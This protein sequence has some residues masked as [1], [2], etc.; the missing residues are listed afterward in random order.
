MKASALVWVCAL[1][2]AFLLGSS[3]F[4]RQT[5]T[6]IYGPPERADTVLVERTD[7]AV[8]LALRAVN[9]RQRKRI[10][11]LEKQQPENTVVT[12]YV[13]AEP[14]TIKV[15]DAP[16]VNFGWL[17]NSAIAG[18]FYGD[19]A[20][21]IATHLSTNP[22]GSVVKRQETA[23]SFATGPLQGV[24]AD[25]AGYRLLFDPEGFPKPGCTFWCMARTM[26]GCAFGATVGA[27]VADETGAALGALGGC[28]IGRTSR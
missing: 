24:I 15:C 6:I 22:A 23:N 4:P 12:R 19:T 2:L 26:L 8:V 1:G 16:P 3:L 14:D 27:A 13:P 7:T 10:A 28:V 25:S 17:V 9:Q 5:R 18:R 20:T 11:E 21:I